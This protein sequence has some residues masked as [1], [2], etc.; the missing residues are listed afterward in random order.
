MPMKRWMIIALALTV[1]LGSSAVYTQVSK[2]DHRPDLAGACT[3]G[4]GE[5]QIAGQTLVSEAPDE[6]V[7]LL[8]G[9][10][11]TLRDTLL[12]KASG[13]TSSANDSNFYGLNAAFA[14]TSG[15]L[16][17]LENVELRSAASGAN[18]VF[19]TGE[20]TMVTADNLRIHTTGNSS[21][22]LFATYGGAIIA[23]N[24]QIATEG[25]HCAPIATD[26]GGGA[27]T[28]TTGQVSAQGAGSPCVYSTGDILLQEVNG[29]A[30][31]SQAAIV[32]GKNSIA[33]ERSSLTG[34]GG[35]AGVMLYQS[36]SGDAAEGTASFSATDSFLTTTAEVPMFYI[37]NTDAEATLARTELSFPGNTLIRA[38][39][40]KHWGKDNENGGHLTLKAVDQRLY[41][42]VEAD[43]IST[44]SLELTENSML[45]GTV[46][47]DNQAARL[48]LSLDDTSA[49]T[50]TGDS[51]VHALTNV[52]EDLSNIYSNGFSLYYDAE[53]E[54]NAWLQGETWPLQGGGMLQPAARTKS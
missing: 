50:L 5:E 33:I 15:S 25:E 20:G 16:A 35:R 41:G 44:I 45:E 4:K 27:V 17:T 48:S 12:E 1:L 13:N 2:A 24:V 43:A 10:T 40:T 30:A 11:L 23:S 6:N 39:G 21:R 26:R 38:E 54:Q 49:W 34:M 19:A 8:A 51:Y 52:L 53:V 47:G 28:V 36:T 31:G 37:T 9:G 32:E 22:G 46:N 3:V 7:L 29:T 14:A 18:A 42:N